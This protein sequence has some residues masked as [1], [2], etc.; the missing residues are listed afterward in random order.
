MDHTSL[1]PEEPVVEEP[2]QVKEKETKP[3][4][5]PEELKKMYE[6][7]KAQVPEGME[8]KIDEIDDEEYAKIMKQGEKAKPAADAKAEDHDEL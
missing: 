1:P 7:L 8:I 6:N 2:E 5:D 3:A 4:P